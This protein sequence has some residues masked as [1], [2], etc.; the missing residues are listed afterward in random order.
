MPQHCTRS[1]QHSLWNDK[2]C[3]LKTERR[4]FEAVQQMFQA[5]MGAFWGDG[6]LLHGLPQAPITF[7]QL[8]THCSHMYPFQSAWKYDQCPPTLFSWKLQPPHQLPIRISQAKTR[9][10]FTSSEPSLMKK[11]LVGIFFDIEKAYDTVWK[12]GI[13]KKLYTAGVHGLLTLFIYLVKPLLQSE[14]K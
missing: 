3:I 2:E 8:P 10:S 14:N 13:L 6:V 5:P 4:Y 9:L 1:R 11:Y 7:Q 12:F